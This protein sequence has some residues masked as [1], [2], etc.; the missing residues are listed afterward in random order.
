MSDAANASIPLTIRQQFPCDDSGRVLW[1]T[2]PPLNNAE[3]LSQVVSSGDGKL[4]QHSEEFL[5]KRE[6]KR[7]LRE[8]REKE[9]EKKKVEEKNENE[10]AGNANGDDLG[11]GRDPKRR[12][13]ATD[14]EVDT[15]VLQTLTNKILD[16]NQ[17]WYRV[18]YGDRAAEIEG[19]D[20]LRS[21][22]RLARV[23]EKKRYFEKRN[24]EEGERRERE[25][26][27]EG[28][29]FRDDRDERY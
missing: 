5:K 15:L 11:D 14:A 20:E 2:T 21:Q 24:R 25:K 18:Q 28:R 26:R 16:S 8:E 7:R 3:S 29:V 22:E 23:Q 6:E 10:Q 12:K 27:L 19:L 1:F 9:K 4:L 13:T 17:E